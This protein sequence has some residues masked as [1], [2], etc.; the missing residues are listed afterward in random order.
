MNLVVKKAG[1]STS[2]LAESDGTYKLEDGNYTWTASKDEYDT[3]TD[4][5]FTVKDAEA[6]IPVTFTKTPVAPVVAEVKID[7]ALALDPA[8]AVYQEGKTP[9]YVLKNATLV[10][11]DGGEIEETCY[12]NNAFGFISPN[13]KS[14]EIDVEFKLEDSCKSK[15][16]FAGGKNTAS[17]TLVF[18]ITKAKAVKPA[19]LPK[20][21]TTLQGTIG[22]ELSTKVLPAKYK[23]KTDG[24]KLA[25]TEGTKVNYKAIYNPD[26]KN[27]EDS[28]AFDLEVELTKAP[29]A[30][31]VKSI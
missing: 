7:D 1:D 29:V 27:Y 21:I 25:V 8:T 14:Y 31:I 30:S 17:K 13:V 2:I 15:Y 10:K 11:A 28:E 19:S 16:S 26:A 20:E 9:K 18:T 4:I 3:Q 23:W 12:T 24:V 22:K 6:T 5:P